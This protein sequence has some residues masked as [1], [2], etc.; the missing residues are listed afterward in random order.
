MMD[1]HPLSKITSTLASTSMVTGITLDTK[2]VAF[3]TLNGKAIAER[4]GTVQKVTKRAVGIM[5]NRSTLSCLPSSLYELTEVHEG[6]E[7]LPSVYAHLLSISA[8]RVLRYC[9]PQTTGD[10]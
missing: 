2:K 1:P 5:T 9:T 3:S 4:E 10:T 7:L 8:C 6:L